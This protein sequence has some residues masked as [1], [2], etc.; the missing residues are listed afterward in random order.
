M[1]KITAFAALSLCATAVF[2]GGIDNKTN[3]STGYLRNPSR[4]TENKR[5]EAVFYNIAGTGFMDDGLYFEVGNQ[6]VFKE[7]SDEANGTTY[8]DKK[9]V[10][11][12]PNAAAVYKNGNWALFGGF[13]VFAGGGE[14]DYKDG[15]YATYGMLVKTAQAYA[16]VSPAYA[17]LFNAAANDHSLSVYS[18][19]FG[20]IFGASYRINDMISVSAAGRLLQGSQNL[21]LESSSLSALNGGSDEVGYDASGIGFGGIFGLHVK[22]T[23]VLDLSVQYQTITKLNFKFDSLNGSLASKMLGV[24]EGDTFHNDLPAVLNL[25]AGYQ[26]TDPLYINTSFNYYFNEQA[27]MDNVLTGSSY[28]YDNSWEAGA[29]ADYKVN[30]TVT[31]STGF[32][33]SNQGSNSTSNNVFSPVLNSITI[34]TG[35]EVKALRNLTVVAAGMVYTK[36]FEKTY[37]NMDLNKKVFLFSLGA[38]FKPF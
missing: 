6:F 9:N 10:Y 11:L 38:T 20:E 22:P 24:S 36:Y 28:D 21:S 7:Y 37:Q 13:A 23:A 16:S 12:Y 29:G 19:T 18:V 15:T 14:L 35:A 27:D 34:G 31:A 1:K 25:G 30:N 3:L 8:K 17:A 32:M 33:Y 2:A 26:L 4:N 5:P